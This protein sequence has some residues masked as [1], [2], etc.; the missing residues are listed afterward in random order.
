MIAVIV[1]LVAEELEIEAEEAALVV[2]KGIFALVRLVMV[3]LQ[4]VNGTKIDL[5]EHLD[6]A[7]WI[8]RVAQLTSSGCHHNLGLQI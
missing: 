4:V 1:N 8:C 3:D 2:I 7:A 6:A 5:C